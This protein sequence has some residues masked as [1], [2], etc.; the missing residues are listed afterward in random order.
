MRAP[1]PTSDIVSRSRGR[2]TDTHILMTPDNLMRNRLPEFENVVAKV[3]TTP[4]RRPA[5]FGQYLLEFGADAGTVRPAGRAH[6]NF[7]YLLEG[8]ATLTIE[9]A[10]H[11][12]ESGGY[13]YIPQGIGFELRAEEG[14]RAL[15]LKRSYVPAEGLEAP[16]VVVSRAQ[17]VEQLLDDNIEG[18]SVKKLLPDAPEFDMAMNIVMMDQGAYFPIVEIHHQEHGLYMLEGQGIYLLG[19]DRLEVCADDYIYMAP[20]CPQY[21]YATGW[22]P[23]AYLLY[24][25]ANRDGFDD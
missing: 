4:R 24:K 25:D 22:S 18:I 5:G 13:G 2:V 23:T 9:G 8:E 11:A 17:D 1:L 19:E 21:Y 12:L 6:E 10:G 7:V 16:G 20:Y 3:L 14:A 15:W